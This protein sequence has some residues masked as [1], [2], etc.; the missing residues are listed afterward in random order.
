MGDQEDFDLAAIER[1]L[2]ELQE[3]MTYLNRKQDATLREL[4]KMDVT[5]YKSIETLRMIAIVT[6]I[7]LLAFVFALALQGSAKGCEVEASG[8]RDDQGLPHGEWRITLCDGTVT[9]G[10]IDHGR[11]HGPVAVRRPDG[12]MEIGFYDSGRKSG[13]WTYGKADGGSLSGDYRDG[14]LDGEWVLR[15]KSGEA[16]VRECWNEGRWVGD[17]PCRR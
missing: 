10:I 7:I 17:G 9:T 8:P 14:L 16:L 1:K 3:G 2:D 4:K 11:W 13:Y 6:I 15:D 5:I 12:R